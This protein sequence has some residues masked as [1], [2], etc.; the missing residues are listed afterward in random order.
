[1]FKYIYKYSNINILKYKYKINIGDLA[2]IVVG[3]HVYIDKD[4]S[5][6]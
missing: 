3:R 1:M 2:P 5:C 4:W 6:C